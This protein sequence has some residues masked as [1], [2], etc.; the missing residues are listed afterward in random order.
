M[1]WIIG[2]LVALAVIALVIK[3]FLRTQSQN[4]LARF[5]LPEGSDKPFYQDP[6]TGKKYDK[7]A[8][9]KHL[10][11]AVRQ[12]SNPQLQSISDRRQKKPDLW[13]DLLSEAARR[14]LLQRA[15]TAPEEDEDEEALEDINERIA[16]FFW[17]EQAAGAS[18]GLSTGTYL[19]DVFAARADE[20]FTGSGEDWNSLAEAYLEDEPALRAR[21]QF[22]SQEDLFS[23]YCR[24]TEMLE[25]FIT[26]FKDACEDRERIVRLFAQARKA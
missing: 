5:E 13:N 3:I 10:E 1:I 24:D 16:P 6:A 2:I 21:L 20:G 14:E 12:F 17:V 19:Q 8:Y 4:V 18:V 9:D 11:A 25:T 23:V 15:N 26:G 22:D 7:E